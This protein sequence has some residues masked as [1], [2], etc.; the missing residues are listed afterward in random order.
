MTFSGV[1]HRFGGDN[2]G[3]VLFISFQLCVH[4]CCCLV[5]VLTPLD[6]AFGLEMGLIFTV[7][8]WFVI[9]KADGSWK[10][11]D[12]EFNSAADWDSQE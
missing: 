10:K 1:V 11:L 9:G 5:S 7:N 4:V 3:F 12:I 2:G 6:I 8:S